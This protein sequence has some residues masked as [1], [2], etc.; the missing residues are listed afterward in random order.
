M[1]NNKL[2]GKSKPKRNSFLSHI[3][4]SPSSSSSN[5]G[6]NLDQVFDFTNISKSTNFSPSTGSSFSDS[7]DRF[8]LVTNHH[9]KNRIDIKD[10]E[11]MKRREDSLE[12][13][14]FKDANEL[15]LEK[16]KKIF[17]L[18]TNTM[19]NRNST[20]GSNSNSSGGDARHIIIYHEDLTNQ[21]SSNLM[22]EKKLENSTY[23]DFDRIKI[24]FKKNMDNTDDSKPILLS[25]TTLKKLKNE[26]YFKSKNG[27]IHGQK[28][29]SI[30][31]VAI[32]ELVKKGI[33]KHVISASTQGQL[34]LCGI[35]NNLTEIY[36]NCYIEICESCNNVVDR[37]ENVTL[38]LKSKYTGNECKKCGGKLMT[39]VIQNGE[40]LDEKKYQ[41]CCQQAEK[42]T[43]NLIIDSRFSSHPFSKF[44]TL[45]D[46]DTNLIVC[47]PYKVHPDVQR[48]L[49]S[50][51]EMNIHSHVFPDDLLLY[52]LEQYK[53][54]IP[55]YNQE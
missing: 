36:G 52:L 34:R 24:N 50:N 55:K 43:L 32:A 8:D 40:V 39:N 7:E 3:F 19:N 21:V 26:T 17:D 41:I 37:Y 47:C 53:I 45:S 20:I 48:T 11:N 10:E 49:S 46:S 18:M 51:K 28:A 35:E 23:Y 31:H 42:C 13:K 15:F 25:I 9:R 2:G 12:V 54:T 22:I 33:V 29:P 30:K 16:R 27:G 4:I 1:S 44:Y 38:N 5:S 14:G 6:S